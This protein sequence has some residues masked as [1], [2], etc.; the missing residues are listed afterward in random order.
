MNGYSYIA[1]T[2]LDILDGLDEIKIGVEYLKAGQIIRHFPSSEQVSDWPCS[3]FI[4]GPLT[5]V[6][7]FDSDKLK[8]LGNDWES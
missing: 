5:A 2:K 8:L 3:G 1:L 4:I 6:I 7:E